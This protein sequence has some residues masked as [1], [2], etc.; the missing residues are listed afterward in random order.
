MT[1]RRRMYLP[2]YTYHIVQ[3]GNNRSACFIEDMD[4]RIYLKYLGE[5]LTRHSNRLHAYC[6]M[7]NHVHLLI[8][9]ERQSGI[10]DQFQVVC[11]RYGQ[12]MNKKYQRTGTLWEGRHKASAIDSNNY[13]FNC[14]RYIEFNPV[15]AGM[16]KHPKDYRWS[17]YLRN[18]YGCED[19]LISEHTNYRQFGSSNK[20]RQQC[21]R[22]IA[23]EKLNELE[24]ERLEQALE[25]S[26]PLGSPSFIKNLESDLGRNIGYPTPGRPPGK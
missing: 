26:Y 4:Y 8:T 25:R 22:H 9:P 12:Y 17:S 21:Y 7:S 10:S 18:A 11:S 2:G 24:I 1:R 5:A 23:D 20:Q 15:A 6:L 16:A 19:A 3:R 14:Y 13:L